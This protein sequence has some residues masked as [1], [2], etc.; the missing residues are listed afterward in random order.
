MTKRTRSL[1]APSSSCWKENVN[2]ENGPLPL[3]HSRRYLAGKRRDTKAGK[4]PGKVNEKEEEE[5]KKGK[6][7][8]IALVPLTPPIH[9]D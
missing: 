4:Q 8:K 5:E 6:E 7:K 2:E 3:R 9:G 1:S